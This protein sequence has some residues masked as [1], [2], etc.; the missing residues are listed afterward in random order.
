MDSKAE[1]AKAKS[2]SKDQTP[3][4]LLLGGTFLA[5]SGSKRHRG[6]RR[7]AQQDAAD[8]EKEASGG[9]SMVAE[10]APFE[11]SEPSEHP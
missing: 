6:S 7:V 1:Q 8:L 11:P 4:G 3:F 10:K 9:F 2:D 5:A